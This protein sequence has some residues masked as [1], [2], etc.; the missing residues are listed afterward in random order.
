MLS[1][2][3]SYQRH[4]SLSL[5]RACFILLTDMSDEECTPY[6]PCRT[7]QCIS[8]QNIGNAMYVNHYLMY[9]PNCLFQQV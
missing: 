9:I 3:Q 1:L 4:F 2:A 5:Y 7:P 8:K 6:I